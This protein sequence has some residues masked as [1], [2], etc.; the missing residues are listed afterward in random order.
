MNR[1]EPVNGVKYR[2]FC[3]HVCMLWIDDEKTKVQ[4]TCAKPIQPAI[5]MDEDLIMFASVYTIGN[6]DHY[7]CI[8]QTTFHS[9]VLAV[10]QANY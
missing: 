6:I 3:L 2:G 10:L 8:T 1:C 5:I 9:V 7:I 4:S